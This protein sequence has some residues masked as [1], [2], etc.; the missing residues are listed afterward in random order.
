MNMNSREKLLIIVLAAVIIL[1]GGFKL[2]I[3][4]QLKSLA[5][6]NISLKEAITKKQVADDNVLRADTIDSENKLL[7]AKIETAAAVFFPELKNDKIQIFFQDL[8]N[9]TGVTFESLTMTDVT[10]TQ[11]INQ[12]GTNTDASYPAKEAADNI[13]G[14]DNNQDVTNNTKS[15][16]AT[17][18]QSTKQPVD[19]VEMMAV[20]IQ[21]KS[22]YEQGIAMVNEIKNSKRTIRISTLNFTVGD[23][24]QF[25]ATISAECY[26]IVKLTDSDILSKDSLTTPAGKTNPFQ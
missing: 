13:S 2:L 22:T 10:T 23:D 24:G 25:T 21:F 12:S 19:T 20:T 6:T 17:S 16:A 8:A 26:G 9:K 15:S 1:M 14:I 5:A 7:E 18:S 11:I 3:E 4:P